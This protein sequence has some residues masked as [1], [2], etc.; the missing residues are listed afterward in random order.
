M[1]RQLEELH[2]TGVIL[3]FKLQLSM[4]DFA[5]VETNDYA[6]H[7]RLVCQAKGG[8]HESRDIIESFLRFIPTL[9][10]V[11]VTEKQLITASFSHEN[12]MILF[13]YDILLTREDKSFWLAIPHAG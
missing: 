5:V 11:S 4:H 3:V 13:R 12:I 8:Y 7:V 10:S 1:D 6:A 2:Q 9:K